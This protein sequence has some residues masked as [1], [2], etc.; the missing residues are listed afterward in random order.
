MSEQRDP[1]ARRHARSN[2]LDAAAFVP[3]VDIDPRVAE[4][5]LGAL[6]VAGIPAYVEPSPGHRGGYLEVRLPDRPTDRLWVDQGQR[7]A[8]REVVDDELAQVTDL[9]AQPVDG[10]PTHRRDPAQEEAAWQQ[11]VAEFNTT[12]DG[13][14]P[15]WPVAEDVDSFEGPRRGEHAEQP[16]VPEE[17][18]DHPPLAPRV[19]RRAEPTF[20]PM[21]PAADPLADE[22]FVPPPP[23]P[24][25]RPS[26]ASLFALLAIGGGVLLL[27]APGL[28]GLARGDGTFAAG[29]LAIVGGT[30]TLIWRMRD[31]P[32]TDSGPDD[33]AVV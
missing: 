14:V 13:P 32:P 20:N 28:V 33:G 24:A 18:E 9:L 5:L 21:A 22:H 25:P 12:V 31:A 19:V 6:Y 16:G 26:A 29:I 7:V 8:A 2:G 17:S 23:P 3:L 27:F 4:A 30:A 1:G 11:I 15:P 10:R